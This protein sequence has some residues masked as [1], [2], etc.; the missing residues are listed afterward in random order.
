MFCHL[1]GGMFS[2]NFHDQMET[3]KNDCL[4]TIEDDENW[5]L[6]FDND[7]NDNDDDDDDNQHDFD[8]KL[9]LYN[10]PIEAIFSNT[11]VS[12]NLCPPIWWLVLDG[13][14]PQSSPY[15][16]MVT[17][18]LKDILD[19]D[20]TPSY[21]HVGLVLASHDTLSTWDLTSPVP[22]VCHYPFQ[23]ATGNINTKYDTDSIQVDFSLTPMDT[24]YKPCVEAALRA[25]GDNPSLNSN[26]NNI[27]SNT[28]ISHRNGMALAPTIEIILEFMEQ[29][30]H[31]GDVVKEEV[32]QDRG[33]SSSSSSSSYGHS[34]GYYFNVKN[35]NNKNISTCFE[36][37]WWQNYCHF[38]SSPSRDSTSRC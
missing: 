30:R 15:W 21:V 6:F 4:E 31:P 26:N 38:G 32:E 25:V 12:A 8:I 19:D 14:M 33:T 29:A 27:N 10:N 9:P 1:C 2:S 3:R 5:P 17:S 28:N 11:G 37:C 18:A 36:V 22:R 24:L 20:G 16:K 13:T 23:T 34:N 7:D 35:N